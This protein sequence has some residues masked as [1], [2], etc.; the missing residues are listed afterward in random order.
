MMENSKSASIYRFGIFE[1]NPQTGEL[2][3]KGVRVRL[4]EQPFQLLLFSSRTT[5]KSC[6][7]RLSVS[8]DG[9]ANTF[10][11]FDPSMWPWASCVS[12][13]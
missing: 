9:R 12:S 5:A 6:G 4:Q 2:K 8:G 10:V 11:D 13:L 3:R 1:A 7:A